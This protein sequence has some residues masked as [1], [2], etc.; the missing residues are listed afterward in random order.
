MIV[1]DAFNAAAAITAAEDLIELAAAMRRG[2]APL[3]FTAHVF[4]EIWHDRI[5][6]LTG[7]Q[8]EEGLERFVNVPVMLEDVL[9]KATLER[10]RPFFWSEVTAQ[11]GLTAVQRKIIE[12]RAAAGFTEGLVS[13][14]P[15]RDGRITSVGLAGRDIDIANPEVR[16]AAHVLAACYG[17]VARRLTFSDAA[18]AAIILTSRQIDCLSWAREGKST[19]DIGVILGISAHTAQEHI[20]DACERLGVRT[21]VQAVAVAISMNLIPR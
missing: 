17:V 4:A 7:S 1:R 8:H 2:I 9:Y 13:A 12:E 21:R 16:A 15:H 14:M 10:K 11:P 19:A 5:R 3:G 20:S 18:P 6:F